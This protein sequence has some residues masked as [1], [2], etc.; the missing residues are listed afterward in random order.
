MVRRASSAMALNLRQLRYFVS[1]V[2]AG[3][4]S[5]AAAN[6][7]VAQPALS[8]QIA[9][10][11]AGLGVSLLHRTPRGVRPTPA[12][13]TLLREATSILRQ[14]E[15]LPGVVRSSGGEPEGP[16]SLGMSSTLAAMFSAPFIDRCK[17]ELPN[18]K[19][20]LIT[21]DSLL[22][23]SQL[24]ASLLDVAV[25]FEDEEAPGFSRWPLFRQRLYLIWSDKLPGGSASISVRELAALPLLLPTHPNVTRTK[26]EQAFDAAGVTPNI[27][28]ESNLMSGLLSAAESGIGGA[29]IPIGH[30]PDVPGYRGLMAIAIEPPIHL[31]A[32]VVTANAFPLSRAG[33]A[34]RNLLVD[35]IETRL[36]AALPPGAER[37][38]E[39]SHIPRR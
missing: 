35:F 13:E 7:N 26:L 12:G 11:E 31:T 38:G 27:F 34:V 25:T 19:L 29:V 4:F 32:H 10:L 24:L 20:R 3:S 30:L 39:A 15:Q 21:G 22:M 16:V 36:Q 23:R 17:S 14:V 2:E 9:E 28:A 6:I 1:I 8:Q 5:R 18:V 33:E 37:I